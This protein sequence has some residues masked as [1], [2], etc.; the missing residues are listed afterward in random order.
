M[1][2]L[3]CQVMTSL[4]CYYKLCKFESS[5]RSVS[6]SEYVLEFSLVIVLVTR[7]LKNLY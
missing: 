4:T 5:V 1:Y 3:E 2:I 6:L 7:T